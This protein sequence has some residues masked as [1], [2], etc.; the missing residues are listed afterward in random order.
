MIKR[1]F[2]LFLLTFVLGV[3]PLISASVEVRV[4]RLGIMSFE[5]SSG[6]TTH[7]KEE[8]KILSEI[9]QKLQTHLPNLK[10]QTRFYRMNDLMKAIAKKEVEICDKAPS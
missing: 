8:D 10:I 3:S 2:L 6:F 7:I 9:A 5:G 1:F 4:L